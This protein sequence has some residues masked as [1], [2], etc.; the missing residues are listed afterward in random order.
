MEPL[1][2]LQQ[3]PEQ[4]F[5]HAR[6]LREV[7]LA[8][9]PNIT[10]QVDLPAKMVAYVYAQKYADMVCVIIPSKKGLKLGFYKGAEL[11]DPDQLLQ[12]S[13]KISRYVVIKD[14]KDI[15][16]GPLKKLITHALAA[17][18]QRSRQNPLHK[19]LLLFLGM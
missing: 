14:Q 6:Q 12:G 11:P 19:K 9:L 1:V 13:G 15:Y 2:F 10:E 3:Y 8:N 16:S 5:S 4:V 7:L 17:C 18:K